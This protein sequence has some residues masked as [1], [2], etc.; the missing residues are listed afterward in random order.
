MHSVIVYDENSKAQEHADVPSV[1]PKTILLSLLL[2]YACEG[3]LYLGFQHLHL[4]NTSFF[5]LID[6]E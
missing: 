3:Y 5:N 2:H 6:I 1:S 4:S